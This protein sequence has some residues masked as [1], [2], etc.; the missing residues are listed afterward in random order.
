MAGGISKSLKTLKRAGSDPV[1]DSYSIAGW[2]SDQVCRPTGVEEMVHT[3]PVRS[4]VGQVSYI[5]HGHMQ[6]MHS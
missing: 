6:K 1:C 5:Q 4:Q 3:D 2:Y